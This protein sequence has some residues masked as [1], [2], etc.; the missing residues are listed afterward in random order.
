MAAAFTPELSVLEAALGPG[1]WGLAASSSLDEVLK[2]R[3]CPTLETCSFEEKDA[4]REG[5]GKTL[6]SKSGVSQH[7][8]CAS[9]ENL[10]LPYCFYG[11]GFSTCQR[12]RGPNAQCVYIDKIY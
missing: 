6:D 11:P 9:R 12:L 5:R 3:S 2:C 10:G 7:A 1:R 4:L 8:Q